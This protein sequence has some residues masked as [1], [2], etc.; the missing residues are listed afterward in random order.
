MRNPASGVT[1]AGPNDVRG[2]AAQ[3][4]SRWPAD[5]WVAR[6]HSREMRCAAFEQGPV[7]SRMSLPRGLLA[8]PA[9]LLASPDLRQAMRPWRRIVPPFSFQPFNLFFSILD[10]DGTWSPFFS[11]FSSLSLSVFFYLNETK[12]NRYRRDMRDSKR[13][14]AVRRGANDDSAAGRFKKEK[15]KKKRLK[16]WSD[17]AREPVG[18]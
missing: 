11:S 16:E 14:R 9:A 13:K 15:G 7:V 6:R 17:L 2:P 8:V 18:G 4:E 10:L 5:D 12:R 1:P 3:L